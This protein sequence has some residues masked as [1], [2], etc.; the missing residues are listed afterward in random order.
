V[1][2]AET[3]SSPP[4]VQGAEP[5]ALR[6][7]GIDLMVTGGYGATTDHRSLGLDLA[8]YGAS[9]GLD[10][11]Y[12]WSFG[13]RIGAYG[14]YSVGRSI[15]QTYNPLVGRPFDL[16]ADTSSVSTGLSVGWDVPIHPLVLRYSVG[17]GLTVMHTDFGPRQDRTLHGESPNKGFHL[18]PGAALLWP[19]DW[20]QGG[21]G[22]RYLVQVNDAIPS[23]FLG[24]LILG[25]R[26]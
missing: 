26:L 5:S 13:L 11:G 10:V 20:F 8:P 19:H 12:A 15:A 17:A 23:G 7:A 25:A 21:V 18:L 1:A 16:D 14:E 24:E 9:V 4:A 6:P 3:A 22:F 2:P